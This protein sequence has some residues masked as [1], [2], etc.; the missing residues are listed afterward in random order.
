[1]ALAGVFSTL[2]IATLVLSC[3]GGEEAPPAAD[4]GNPGVVSSGGMV[5]PNTFMTY[6]GKQYRLV[7]VLQ[8]NLI[9]EQAFREIGST[10]QADIDFTESLVVF[11][12]DGDSGGLYTFSKGQ[13]TGEEAVP[14]TWLRWVLAD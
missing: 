13:G 8:A 6:E 14:A 4:A 7:E 1:M 11:R 9:N 12:R 2:L 10:R 3:G 5:V